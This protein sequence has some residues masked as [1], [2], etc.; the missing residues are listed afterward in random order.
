[1]AV[2]NLVDHRAKSRDMAD[3]AEIDAV[4]EPIEPL[5]TLIETEVRRLAQ[6]DAQLL[7]LD[8]GVL[9]RGLAAAEARGATATERAD[10]LDGLDRLRGLEDERAGAMHR[11]FEAAAL[12]RRAVDLGLE[13]GHEEAHYESQLKLAL[14]SLQVGDESGS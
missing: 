7:Q 10:L 5:I 6:L 12:S 13:V 14:A 4:T 1:M 11:L 9:V 2:Q 3:K 8:E